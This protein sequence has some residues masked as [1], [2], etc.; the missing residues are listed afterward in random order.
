MFNL[1]CMCVCVARKGAGSEVKIYIERSR[2]GGGAELIL[3]LRTGVLHNHFPFEVI[4][5][6]PLRIIVG[7]SINNFGTLLSSYIKK[8]YM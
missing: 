7:K 6:S 4:L 8:L 2:G 1:A 3:L 5:S